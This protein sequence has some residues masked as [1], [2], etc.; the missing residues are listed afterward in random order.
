M[1]DVTTKTLNTR[2]SQKYD[3]Y[4]QWIA[5]DPALLKG[6]IAVVTVTTAVKD[7]KGNIVQVPNLMIKVG[8]DGVKK[9]SELPWLSAKAADVA[10]WAKA[11]TLEANAISGLG[12][13]IANYVDETLGISVD[14]NT[15]YR[16]YTEDNKTYKLQSKA[17]GEEDTAYADVTGSTFTIDLSGVKGDIADLEALVG[18]TAVATQIG[19]AISDLNLANTYEAKGEAAKVTEALETYKGTNDAAVKANTDAIAAIK[20]HATIDS[21]ADVAAELAKKQD[22]GDYATK[23]DAQGY[24]DAKDDAIAAAQKA[25]DDAQD[26]VDALAEKVG[27]VEEGKTVVGMIADAQTAATYNDTEVKADIADLE[28]LVGDTAVATQISDAVAAEKTRAEGIEGGLDGRITA[29]EEDYLKAADKE[30]LQTQ[31]NT[32]MSNPDAEGAINSINEFTQYVKDHGT[33]AEGFRTDIDANADAIDAIEADYL[34]AADKTELQGNIDAV[35]GRV[36]TAEGEIDDLQEAVATKAAQSD[37][38]ALEAL[39]GDT[40]VATQITNAINDAN[41]GQ[42]AKAS[43]LATTQGD[44]DTLEETVSGLAAIAK[45]GNVNDLVQTEGDVLVFNCGTASTVI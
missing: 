44:L 29:I 9:F 42:Y 6:E 30:A 4:D 13:Y 39:V 23:A 41:L 22:N 38:D 7:D 24:A 27:T 25:A 20:D 21:F 2:I 1:A 18:D 15:V 8:E 14:T 35:E 19:N 3:T 34:K 26:A 12:D 33:I 28:E 5:N 43:D 16:L 31:I 37:L 36:T 10:D 40:A 32:I 11:D 17:A 45:T